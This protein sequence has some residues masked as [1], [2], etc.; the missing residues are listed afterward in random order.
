MQDSDYCYNC[1]VQF[2]AYYVPQCFNANEDYFGLMITQI[3]SL[4]NN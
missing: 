3:Y 1:T 4:G 2:A